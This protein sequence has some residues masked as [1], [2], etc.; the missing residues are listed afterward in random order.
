MTV[1]TDAN[2][3]DEGPL[4]RMATSELDR[5][6]GV[7]TSGITS[8]SHGSRNVEVGDD[9]IS[10][11]LEIETSTHET[12]LGIEGIGEAGD[13][14]DLRRLVEIL[15]QSLPSD[16]DRDGLKSFFS[17]SIGSGSAISILSSGNDR[18]GVGFGRGFRGVGSGMCG[19]LF[20]DSFDKN[21]PRAFENGCVAS[22]LER[23]T[24]GRTC[25]G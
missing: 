24:P 6:A 23:C 17:G 10:F 9:M 13:G 7:G 4:S 3:V 21:G 14:L 20:S 11:G 1:L 15:R 16:M 2:E 5:G 8:S 12:D 18:R 25:G 22:L 19:E